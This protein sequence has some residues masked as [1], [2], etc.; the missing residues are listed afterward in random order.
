MDVITRSDA[1]ARG[2][3]R[4][5]TGK[6]CP[7]NHVSER[8]LS[9]KKC[10]ECNREAN[11]RNASKRCGVEWRRANPGYHKKYL[12]QNPDRA[13]T[14]AKAIR[15]WKV[16]N[17]EKVKETGRREYARNPHRYRQKSA[18]KIERLRMSTPAW[19]DKR[20]IESVYAAA[21]RISNGS[22]IAHHVDHIV[23]LFG[24]NV[25]GLHVEGNLQILSAELN[26]RKSNHF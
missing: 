24:R 26:R 10:V 13:V 3:R 14:V 16:S 1:R 12:A 18:A 22:G 4:Y 21:R 5:F 8:N 23:P 19:A 11:R 17:P 25:C 15:R 6:P 7:R 20:A 2:L 9:D